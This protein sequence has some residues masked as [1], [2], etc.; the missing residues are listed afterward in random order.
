ML[1]FFQVGTQPLT[2]KNITLYRMPTSLDIK[3]SVFYQVRITSQILPS[4]MV[5]HHW[6]SWCHEE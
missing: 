4:S 5:R 2:N 1:A 6:H 3:S